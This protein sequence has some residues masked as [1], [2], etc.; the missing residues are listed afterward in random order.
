[1][2]FDD[3]MATKMLSMKKALRQE[4]KQ[5]ISNMSIEEKLLQSNYVADKVY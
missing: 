5:I 4:M 2:S 1:M 3:Q